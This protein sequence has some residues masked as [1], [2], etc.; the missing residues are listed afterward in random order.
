M[1]LIVLQQERHGRTLSTLV[2]N[3]RAKLHA[4][5]CRRTCTHKHMHTHTHTHRTMRS[6]TYTKRLVKPHKMSKTNINNSKQYTLKEAMAM[7]TI[8]ASC[9]SVMSLKPNC[10]LE[11]TAGIK[12]AATHSLPLV[13]S[14]HIHFTQDARVW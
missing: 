11:C 13:K 7:H 2:I 5:N 10:T 9:E 14:T 12:M 1:D 4:H 8:N 3:N 6:S